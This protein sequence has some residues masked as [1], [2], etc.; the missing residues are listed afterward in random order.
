MYSRLL[1]VSMKEKKKNKREE[2]YSLI[3]VIF[4]KRN[5]INS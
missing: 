1:A 5:A 4:P 2:F 3:R